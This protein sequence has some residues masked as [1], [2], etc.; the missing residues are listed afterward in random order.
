MNTT[1][2][3]YRRID[4]I[5]NN[6]QGTFI[7]LTTPNYTGTVNILNVSQHYITVKPVKAS[8]P[9]KIHKNSILALKGFRGTY[10][11]KFANKN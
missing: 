3:T 5:V 4:K 1:N 7:S 8:T 2:K 11:R 10:N 6:S 9:V